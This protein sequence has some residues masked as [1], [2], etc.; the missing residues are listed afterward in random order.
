MRCISC[1][2]ENFGRLHDWSYDF[3][4]G[5]SVICEENGW[6]K[7]TFS[8]FIRAMF[9]GLEGE[10]KR[11]LEENERKRYKPWQGG[12]FGGELTFA[13]GEK[14]YTVTR[15]F[16]EK[17]AQDEFE[18]RDAVTNLI[19]QDYSSRLGEELFLINRESFMRTVFLNQNSCETAT[20]DDINAKIGNLAD[21]SNDMNNYE[22]ANARLTEA[23]NRLTPSRITG[24]I[25]KR[26]DEIT[27]L[28]RMVTD[29]AGISDSIEAYQQQLEKEQTRY[30]AFRQEQ[31][32]LLALQEKASKWQRELAK[33][34]EWER[35]KRIA[36]MR[37]EALDAEKAHFSD[38]LPTLEELHEKI[39]ECM[40]LEQEKQQMEHTALTSS[41][42]E[43]LAAYQQEFAEEL[44]KITSM[45]TRWNT[46]NAKKA[47]LTSKKTALQDMIAALEARKQK[48]KP[49]LLLCIAG[50]LLL[51]LGA[52]MAVMKD[53]ALGGI[54][55]VL[56]II[57]GIAGA[58]FFYKTKHPAE[59]EAVSQELTSL[60]KTIHEDE[61]YLQETDH[62]IQEFLS[63]HQKSYEEYS[64]SAFLQE[65]ASCYRSLQQKKT[66]F[67]EAKESYQRRLTELSSFLTEYG[68]LPE[69]DMQK[70]FFDIRDRIEGCQ[71]AQKL[72]HEAEQEL[73]EFEAC[74]D[75]AALQDASMENDLPSLEE[76]A[77]KMQS[78]LDEIELCRQNMAGG[79]R[80]IEGLQAEYD[81]WMESKT[82]LTQQQELQQEE[83][84]NHQ[85][86]LSARENLAKAKQNMTAKYADPILE[87][88]CKYF[89]EIT[90]TSAEHIKMDA[91]TEVSIKELGKQRPVNAFS[92][93]YRDLIGICLRMA[94]VDAMYT[95]EAPI[96]VMDDPFANLDDGKIARAKGFLQ[97]LSQK[98]QIVYLTCSKGRFYS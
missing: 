62:M 46:R 54:F 93:G 25:A 56:G 16:H 94:L 86:L 37:K 2:I 69:A 9:Y 83:K 78:L 6:G 52:V 45:I 20:T 35:L 98:Y 58:V 44:D 31:E 47:E 76:I 80:T 81:N 24:S 4:E 12:V 95:E 85:Y 77:G 29:G 1:H 92:A 26:N 53:A 32:S 36:Q 10:R 84:Q 17:E 41:E 66:A 71:N 64:V 34:E 8:A 11:S 61:V 70:Q 23:I 39:R 22:T 27:R 59:E 65:I 43:T 7:S 13:V 30:D 28:S 67:E 82:L 57:M 63:K 60:Q 49:I 19:S 72:Y 97:E 74:T 15:I 5:L 50:V 40:S 55:V 75:T 90:A 42:E 96:L 33:K 88:F 21:Y 73:S 51:V 3:A 68:F 87:S 48:G 79:K 91:N 18:L 14:Q 89:E 38:R